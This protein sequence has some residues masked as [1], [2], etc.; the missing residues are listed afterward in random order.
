MYC[1]WTQ[2]DTTL[3]APCK[4]ILTD[5]NYTPF[6]NNY[7]YKKVIVNKCSALC[8]LVP[9]AQFTKREKQPWRSV[10]FGKVAGFSLQ[11]D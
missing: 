9:F 5:S 1:I 4:N 7:D 6:I 3:E 10:N 8:D 11:L 2:A